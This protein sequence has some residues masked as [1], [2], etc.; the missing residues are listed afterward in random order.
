MVLFVDWLIDCFIA[1]IDACSSKDTE[2]RADMGQ[3]LLRL[4]E[5]SWELRRHVWGDKRLCYYR[6]FF[7][8]VNR[9]TTIPWRFCDGTFGVPLLSGSYGTGI[10]SSASFATWTV[11][12]LHDDRFKSAAK[13]S[14]DGL[15]EKKS[16]V[17]AASLYVPTDL[18]AGI[19]LRVAAF[20]GRMRFLSQNVALW[21]RELCVNCDR[22]GCG[23][24]CLAVNFISN[25]QAQIP[26]IDQMPAD[27]SS[28]SCEECDS[29]EAGEFWKLILP[30]TR[31]VA[32][33]RTFCS[34]A[35]EKAYASELNLAVTFD[36]DN[37]DPLLHHP[38]GKS[39][40]SRVAA[41]ARSCW[42]RNAT[43]AR[44][45][46]EAKRTWTRM[47][48]KTLGPEFIKQLQ[49]DV[50]DLLN[51][52]LALVVAAAAVAESQEAAKNRKLPAT[53]AHWRSDARAY[54]RAIAAIRIIYKN[55]FKDEDGIAFDQRNPPKW[56]QSV[57]DAR[58]SVFPISVQ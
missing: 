56:L 54:K 43:N 40:L 8:S 51:I 38:I 10:P 28:D 39:G 27:Y 55:K 33:H 5:V 29:S 23:V 3:A 6:Y 16:L 48:F 13:L 41:E 18:P 20:V 46:R 2:L 12:T 52:D 1:S 49:A 7:H 45:L 24:P 58:H 53:C 25:N 17:K 30:K 22:A 37:L 9:Q 44:A 31:A 21:K 14:T 47:R 34:L 36:V 11:T 42:V 4:E 15:L 32:P 35:C 50:R 57:V 19:G 26:G